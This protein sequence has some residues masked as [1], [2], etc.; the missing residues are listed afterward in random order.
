MHED[1]YFSMGVVQK[2]AG[3]KTYFV[4]DDLSHIVLLVPLNWL[5]DIFCTREYCIVDDNLFP[6]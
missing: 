1:M 4:N 5:S 3:Q 6:I 2:P